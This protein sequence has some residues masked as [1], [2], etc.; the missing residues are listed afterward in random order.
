MFT[1]SC[2]EAFLDNLLVSDLIVPSWVRPWPPLGRLFSELD[3]RALLG[4]VTLSND[5]RFFG[6][7]TKNVPTGRR[8][9]VGFAKTPATSVQGLP[10]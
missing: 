1:S 5:V 8:I 2:V 9:E 6:S 7:P 3:H 4:V 10:S